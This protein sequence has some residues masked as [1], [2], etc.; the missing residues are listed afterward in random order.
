MIMKNNIWIIREERVSV[1][2]L[3]GKEEKYVTI[4]GYALSEKE[5]KKYIK[6]NKPL[7][8]YFDRYVEYTYEE[9]SPLE[10]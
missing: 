7:E 2:E 9:V 1:G 6:N 3:N 5:A 4:I 10:S 8:E